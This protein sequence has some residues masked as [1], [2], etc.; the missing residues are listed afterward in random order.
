MT[1]KELRDYFDAI[2]ERFDSCHV[3][4]YT[5]VGIAF[6]HKDIESIRAERETIDNGLMSFGGPP[7]VIIQTD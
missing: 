4:V 7:E 5:S 1:V 6:V 3:R 2:P